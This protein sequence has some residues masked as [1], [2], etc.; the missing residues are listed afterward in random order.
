MDANLPAAF[1]VVIGVILL[2]AIGYAI[3]TATGV[4]RN[5]W[6]LLFIAGIIALVL[7]VGIS[8][9]WWKMMQNSSGRLSSSVEYL[10]LIHFILLFIFGI[11]IFFAS[12]LTT[13]YLLFPFLFIT[14]MALAFIASEMR[15]VTSTVFLTLYLIFIAVIASWCHIANDLAVSKGK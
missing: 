8:F 5:M 6:I 7:Y 2:I 11:A 3:V 12:N 4:A 9:S 14:A 15:D 1:S 13:A 10:F